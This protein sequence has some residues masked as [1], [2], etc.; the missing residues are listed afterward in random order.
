[1][2]FSLGREDMEK[3]SDFYKFIDINKHG[4]FF[5]Y[6]SEYFD[7]NL[8]EIIN[9]LENQIDEKYGVSYELESYNHRY[10]GSVHATVFFSLFLC[11]LLSEKGV[12]T[13]QESL[14]NL[15]DENPNKKF[16]KLPEDE[17]AWDVIEGP[18]IF[19]TAIS[20]YSLIIS[21]SDRKDE[22]R[23]SLEWI[24]KNQNEDI[25]PIIK[26]GEGNLFS[27]LYCYFA[28]KSWMVRNPD[29]TEINS[30]IETSFNNVLTF[31]KDSTEKLIDYRDDQNKFSQ[32]EIILIL[33]L[34]K[35]LDGKAYKE[36]GEYLK[37]IL[38]KQL[39]KD[40]CW[41]ISDLS[42]YKTDAGRK[43]MYSYTP[44]FIPILLSLDWD[45]NDDLVIAF[46]SQ[47]ILDLQTEWDHYKNPVPWRSSDTYIQS[48]I[49]SL[50]IFALYRWFK[51]YLR[52][53][54]NP[55]TEK[56]SSGI[57]LQKD[58]F[59]CYSKQNKEEYVAPLVEFLEAN[60]ISV[61]ID[62]GEILWGDYDIGKIQE[63]KNKS[64]FTI[65]CLSKEWLNG[66]FPR[67][68]FEGGLF[69]QLSDKNK[70]ILPLILNGK[71]LIFHTYP[72]IKNISYLEWGKGLPTILSSLRKVLD[73]QY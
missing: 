12:K 65:V 8:L 36:S 22:I 24:L 1:V 46:L 31:I 27:T 54:V 43:N 25:W 48:F 3:R 18:N 40:E 19:S 51:A 7:I 68:E 38:D 30:K 60:N 53:S 55:I 64:R 32:S 71:N 57:K 11:D 42:K 52:K 56:I 63:G 21:D 35:K 23:Q 70:V 44:A 13:F 29:N 17:F 37:S 72:D 62:Q 69:N 26:N 66:D 2:V 45:V 28:L 61:W 20:C 67:F 5:D 6:L 9:K 4:C 34:L 59:I 14:L 58:V 33:Y 73:E 15:R 41:Y 49:V 39:R 16:A 47:I 50:S 10:Y